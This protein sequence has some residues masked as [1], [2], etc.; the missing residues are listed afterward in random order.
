[1]E[2]TL[3]GKIA[4]VTGGAKG[5]G[6][7]TAE[8][9]AREGAEVIIAD[10]LAEQGTQVAEEICRRGGAARF[11][12]T[13]VSRHADIANLFENLRKTHGGPD[14]L[15]NNAYWSARGS[16]ET[17]SEEDWDRGM[18]TMVK[19]VFLMSKYAFP[20]MRNRGGGVIINV[21]SVHARVAW[22]EYAV[23][24]A[25]KA[26]IE[27]LTR[28]M[29][30]D[31]GPIGIRVNCVAPG[32]IPITD[33]PPG[34]DWRIP[35]GRRGKPQE[36]A[37]VIRFLA[38]DEAAYMTGQTLTIDGGMTA[39]LAQPTAPHPQAGISSFSRRAVHSWIQSARR[40]F[41]PPRRSPAKSY[42]NPQGS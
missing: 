27:S 25:A 19:S 7:Q 28:Q 33:Q 20:V 15:V 11:I 32:S 14:I 42:D 5:I 22:P 3:S 36:V 24:S 9:L 31:G 40:I 1:L 37:G 26:A 21:S 2:V 17:L 10:I 12:H 29:A 6:K 18:D 41:A 34:Q 16:V 39:T 38:S 8:C 13:D 23:Y 30:V 35:M 4:I